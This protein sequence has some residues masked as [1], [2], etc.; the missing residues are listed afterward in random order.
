MP[1]SPSDDEGS[2]DDEAPDP[3]PNETQFFAESL[4]FLSSQNPL[5]DGCQT[6]QKSCIKCDEAGDVL[7]CTGSHCPITIHSSC[8]G[9]D[10]SFTNPEDFKCPF[11]SYLQALSEYNEARKKFSAA[12]KTLSGLLGRGKEER[13]RVKPSSPVRETKPSENPQNISKQLKAS[14]QERVSQL[15]SIAVEPTP[16]NITKTD[17][18]HPSSELRDQEQMDS[19]LKDEDTSTTKTSNDT[20]QKESEVNAG[21]VPAT[22]KCRK[23]RRAALKPKH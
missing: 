21:A 14:V 4:R 18:I 2:H 10:Y 22:A 19:D 3:C 15:K 6:E 8:L 9:S 1:D 23:P 20:E 17:R 11:C 13:K 5:S 16:S 7:E 12:K